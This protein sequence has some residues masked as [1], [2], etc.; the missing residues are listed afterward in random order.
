MFG[1]GSTL[2]KKLYM[3]MV[4]CLFPLLI[5]IIYLLVLVNQS[6]QRYDHIVKKITMANAYN[7]DFK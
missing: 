5:M 7:I 2:D 6:S 3:L 4:V 1:K